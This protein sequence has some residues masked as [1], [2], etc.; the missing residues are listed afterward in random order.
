MADP[1]PG[2]KSGSTVRPAALFRRKTVASRAPASKASPKLMLYHWFPSALRSARNFSCGRASAHGPQIAMDQR[3]RRRERHLGA[4]NHG[5]VKT[6]F[7]ADFC[8][9]KLQFTRRLDVAAFGMTKPPGEP[10]SPQTKLIGYFT[11]G[12]PPSFSGRNASSPR[13]VA[14]TFSR[15]HFDCDSS[16]FLTSSR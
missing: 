15:S 1:I 7:D 9:E 14:T 13:T 4:Q 8:I 16:G 12:Q 5:G 11:N 2:Q 6:P 3:V 10:E